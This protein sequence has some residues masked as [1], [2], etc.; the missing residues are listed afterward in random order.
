MRKI[1]TLAA[2]VLASFS[3]MAE[4]VTLVDIN[5]KDA[6]W[7]GKTF[8]QKGSN[9]PDVI[10]GIYFYSKN[11]DDAKQFS[12]AENETKGLRFPGNNIKTDNYFFAIPLTD[13]HEYIE[14]TLT[15]EYS[16]SKASFCYVFA[17]G[18]EEFSSSISTATAVKDEK[19]ASTSIT[20]KVDATKEKGFLYIG[21]QGS[22]FT[23]IV[24]VKVVS[25]KDAVVAVNIHL[26]LAQVDIHIR[27]EDAGIRLGGRAQGRL[28]VDL[29]F[30]RRHTDIQ[31]QEEFMG[32]VAHGADLRYQIFGPLRRLRP[33]LVFRLKS[34]VQSGVLP[35]FLL[36]DL[37]KQLFFCHV[38]TAAQLLIG[39]FAG[40]PL[41]LRDQLLIPCGNGGFDH[42]GIV[43]DPVLLDGGIL[44]V[45][46]PIDALLPE[47]PGLRRGGRQLNEFL[48]D[49]N[50]QVRPD[51]GA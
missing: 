42:S 39:F 5:F 20:F 13:V 44:R 12:L 30:C 34:L 2:A 22:N 29:R 21:R 41:R 7:T 19:D 27:S 28:E 40:C 43:V 24:G 4:D 35:A 46:D 23:H 31:G 14:V 50:D 16:G 18:L 3:L 1:F 47:E 17:D 38:R 45:S 25:Q 49:R 15:H 36:K 32:L 10:N 51:E 26:Q 33:R 48:Q 6:S 8:A 37:Q 9:T 11:S